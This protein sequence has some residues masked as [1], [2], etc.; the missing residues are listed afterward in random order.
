MRVFIAFLVVGN[1]VSFPIQGFAQDWREQVVAALGN[2]GVYVE[3][4]RGRALLTHRVDEPFVPA[5]TIK[6]ATAVCTLHEL[7]PSYRFSTDIYQTENGRLFVKGYG[8]PVL[9]SEELALIAANVVRRGVRRVTGIALDDSY[10]AE[11][12]VIDGVE[13]SAHPFDALNSALLVNFNTIHV[14]KFRNGRIE[15]AEPQTPLTPIA[16]RMVR[17]LPVGTHRVNLS[18]DPG[19]ALQQV[20]ELLAAFLDREGVR[21]EGPIGRGKTP[22]L[23]R[24][25]YRH[26]S[27]HRLPDILRGMLDYSTNLTANQLFLAMGANRFGPPA[28]VA[29]GVRVMAD[30]LREHVGWNEVRVAEGSGLSRRTLVTPRQMMQLLRHFAPYKELLPVKEEV[31]VAKTGTLNGANAFA[32]YFP[33]TR[34]EARFVILVNDHVPFAHKFRIAKMI[35]AGVN[36]E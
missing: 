7:G 33:T 26:A 24:L 8:D 4:A 23:A 25:L 31:F 9:I 11:D 10:F 6:I 5:S 14:R 13:R 36:H 1:L 35:Y 15:S 2:G 32:G 19:L 27:S 3:E 34:G 22:P 29:K 30:C 12:I 18:H 17:R 20:G 16:S 21:V 28:T